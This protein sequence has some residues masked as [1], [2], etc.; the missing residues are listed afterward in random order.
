MCLYW[1]CCSLPAAETLNNREA[2]NVLKMA[3]T[4]DG[5]LLAQAG[6]RQ[7]EVDEE[8]KAWGRFEGLAWQLTDEDVVELFQHVIQFR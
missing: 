6:R 3:A 4:Y 1:Y 2:L 8:E 7:K 5:R